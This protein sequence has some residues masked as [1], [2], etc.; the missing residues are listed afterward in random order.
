MCR[1]LSL[2][3]HGQ[4]WAVAGSCRKT[5]TVTLLQLL[6]SAVSQQWAV[7]AVTSYGSYTTLGSGDL[8]N[9]RVCIE[10]SG[11][12][13]WPIEKAPAMLSQWSRQMPWELPLHP[14]QNSNSIIYYYYC[15][16]QS[17]SSIQNIQYS[18]TPNPPITHPDPL[19]F[20]S[21]ANERGKAGD[22]FD[23]MLLTLSMAHAQSV[24]E[25]KTNLESHGTHP[26]LHPHLTRGLIPKKSHSQRG[27]RITIQSTIDC[28]LKT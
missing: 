21:L 9:E 10:A 25:A 7:S 28:L 19:Q 24:T 5:V 15:L 23:L 26:F 17:S 4:T 1:C 12:S 16:V 20:K 27:S 3:Q 13:P 8:A 14:V 22:S 2:P 18:K 6:H 11:R